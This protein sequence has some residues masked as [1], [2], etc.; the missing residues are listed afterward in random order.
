MLNPEL[1]SLLCCPVCKGDLAYDEK[2]ER[3][4][5]ARCGRVYPVK[6]NI[7]VLLPD[8]ERPADSR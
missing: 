4:T 6:N 1:L 3:L 7:P 2:A 5:C 8:D